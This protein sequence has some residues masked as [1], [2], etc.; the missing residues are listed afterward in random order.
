MDQNGKPSNLDELDARIRAAQTAEQVAKPRNTGPGRAGAQ[1]IGLGMRISVE[2]VVTTAVG[3][4]IGYGL[5]LWLDTSP[6]LLVVF[7]FLGGAA[8]VMNVYRVVNGLDDTVGLGR[9]VR[10]KEDT[11]KKAE[12]PDAAQE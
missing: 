3:T 11:A 10:Q 8:A 1:G 12:T 4:G 6:L 7:L 9:A 2:L 5:D